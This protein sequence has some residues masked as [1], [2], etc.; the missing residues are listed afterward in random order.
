MK[1]CGTPKDEDDR[2]GNVDS[3]GQQDTSHT[4][5]TFSCTILRISNPTESQL[6]VHITVLQLSC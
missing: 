5:W 4:T 3:M 6:F 1:I 2:I